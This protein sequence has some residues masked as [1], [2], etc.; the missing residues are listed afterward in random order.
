MEI[1][2]DCIP[3][4]R[5]KNIEKNKNLLKKIFTEKEMEYCLKRK[6]S[7]Q[8]FAVRF[9]AKEA[10]LKALYPLNIILPLNQIEILNQEKTGQPYVNIKNLPKKLN[11]KLSLSHAGNMAI[12]HALIYK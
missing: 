1:G 4:S 8:H 9:A 7:K 3:I 10:I 5:F 11:I 6:P 2:V 12:A